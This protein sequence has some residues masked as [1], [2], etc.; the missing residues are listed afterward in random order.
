MLKPEA[1]EGITKDVAESFQRSKDRWYG[2]AKRNTEHITKMM[3]IL[4]ISM[5]HPI[6]K[7]LK[8]KPI[9]R[10]QLKNLKPSDSAIS[11]ALPSPEVQE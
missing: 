11:D 1:I 6:Y 9:L 2:T 8:I 4:F 10:E 3:D 7:G 5:E